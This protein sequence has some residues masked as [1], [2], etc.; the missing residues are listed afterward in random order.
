MR[1]S[2]FRSQHL[3]WLDASLS[4]RLVV[5]MRAHADQCPRCRRFDALLRTGLLLA[6]HHRP[7]APSRQ[8]RTTLATRL[9]AESS[10]PSAAILRSYGSRDHE[11]TQGLAR[12]RPVRSGLSLSRHG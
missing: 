12:E 11:G 2:S 10:R 1:C 4:P 6:R 5:E 7:L 8:F 9:A 3:A